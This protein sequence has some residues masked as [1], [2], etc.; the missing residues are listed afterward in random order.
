MASA[1]RAAVS[2]PTSSAAV[3][4]Q[5]GSLVA[6][7]VDSEGA[8]TPK[9]CQVVPWPVLAASGAV[10]AEAEVASE[11]E[12]EVASVAV[13]TVA[14]EALEAATAASADHQTHLADRAAADMTVI[15]E[16]TEIAEAVADTVDATTTED[17]AAAEAATE[18]VTG[19][20]PEA[21][22]CRS[23]KGTA[24]T[25]TEAATAEIETATETGIAAATTTV[26]TRASGPTKEGQATKV[27]AN[28][29]AT[30]DKTASRLVVGILSPLISLMSSSTSLAS[31][32]TRVSRR[33]TFYNPGQLQTSCLKVTPGQPYWNHRH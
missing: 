25:E 7:V 27:N 9:P 29:A 26:T 6:S 3:P 30:D 19:P 21:M 4:S 5:A 17:T 20:A 1:S 12:I 10:S 18:E 13:S 24:E 33:R 32:T 2:R 11:E 31:L 14:V 22:P 28:C 15:A 8:D 16:I 23:A